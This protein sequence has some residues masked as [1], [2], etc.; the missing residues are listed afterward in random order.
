MRNGPT[1]WQEQCD[2]SRT[3]QPELQEPSHAQRRQLLEHGRDRVERTERA[4]LEPVP[5]GLGDAPAESGHL[6]SGPESTGLQRQLAV[7]HRRCRHQAEEFLSATLK[8]SE[9]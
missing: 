4:V 6:V 8:S 2:P 5:A 1:V 7:H 3:K 9:Y